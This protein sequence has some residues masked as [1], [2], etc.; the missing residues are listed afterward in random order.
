VSGCLFSPRVRQLGGANGAA[1]HEEVSTRVMIM[2]MRMAGLGTM[3]G[4]QDGM[5]WTH[6]KGEVWE[7][8]GDGDLHRHVYSPGVMVYKGVFFFFFSVIKG[9]WVFWTTPRSPL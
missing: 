7:E 2:I 9:I 1:A 3:G 4:K 6:E 5:A 8:G